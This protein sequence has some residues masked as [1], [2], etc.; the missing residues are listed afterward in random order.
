[1]RSTRRILAVCVSMGCESPYTNHLSRLPLKTMGANTT[2]RTELTRSYGIWYS[3]GET[4]ST[5][6]A[7]SR[8]CATPTH[9]A[10]WQRHR[11]A[12]CHFTEREHYR[13]AARV[14][15]DW[16][17]A[18]FHLLVNVAGSRLYTI[19]LHSPPPDLGTQPHTILLH[20]PPVDFQFCSDNP[21]C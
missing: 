5:W 16:R 2:T 10:P 17:Q 11:T 8:G 1:V 4:K 7:L 14:E 15:F 3:G 19:L 12:Y 18:Y 13:P 6:Q 21:L 9:P 20:P